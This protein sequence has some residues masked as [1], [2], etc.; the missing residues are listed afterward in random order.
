MNCDVH[1]CFRKELQA[2]KNCNSLAKDKQ[3]K[4]TSFKVAHPQFI[5]DTREVILSGLQIG[6]GEVVSLTCV[7]FVSSRS[8]DMEHRAVFTADEYA[9]WRL[10]TNEKSTQQLSH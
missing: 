8:L 5:F 7:I 2:L 9:F 3:S 1:L 10:E 4:T 6:Q